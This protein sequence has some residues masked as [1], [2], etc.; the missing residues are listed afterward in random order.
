[1]AL[2]CERLLNLEPIK[3][4]QA[5]DAAD[6]ILYALGVGAGSDV[7][8]DPAYLR[9]V[10]EDGLE[11]L[12]TMSVVL[13][14]PGPWASNP[15]LG[16]DYKRLL[17]AEQSIIL[18]RKVPTAGHVV[19]TTTVEAIY[20]K[21]AAKGALVY[22]S[23]TI[24]D[25]ASGE[26]IA[27]VRFSY[28]L[29]SDGGF[30]GSSEG[31]PKPHPTPIERAP[32]GVIDLATRPEQALLYRLSG[33]Y[34]PLHAAPAAAH[35]AG[36]PR[37]ILHGLCTYG[38]AGRAALKLVCGDDPGRLRRFDA[39]FSRPVYPGETLRTEVWR[40][41]PGRAALSVRA[42]ERDIV[43]LQNGLVEFEE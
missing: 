7:E 4:V 28:F 27:T 10:Y 32:D 39:R 30:G 12:P 37:P 19:G 36:F 8:C 15:A 24:A 3:T 42:I 16:L 18:H 20:D 26:L 41:G 35:Q 2:D 1:M 6:T 11:A 9:Y 29:R 22:A 23:R 34:N 5:Y 38:V 31:A 25:L 43:V 17:H 40:E 14:F 13:A 33:D 21:G